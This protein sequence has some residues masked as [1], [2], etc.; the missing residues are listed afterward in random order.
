MIVRHIEP[1]F[2]DERGSIEDILE[3]EELQHATI[4]RSAAGAVRGNHY[5]ER[6]WQWV[7][8]LTGA[9]RYVVRSA[10]G[11]TQSG[12]VRA[13]DLLLTCP[14]ESHALETLEET[15]ML[16]LTRGPRGGSGYEDDTFRLDEPLIPQ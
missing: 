6:T 2:Q 11:E 15:A 1:V 16:V 4:I 12:I 8:V 10:E 3:N 9:I 7:F 13:N 5:H 14:G